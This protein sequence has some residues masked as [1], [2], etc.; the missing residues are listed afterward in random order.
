MA[1]RC[2]VSFTKASAA[3]PAP[4][5]SRSIKSSA[6]DPLNDALPFSDE[7]KITERYKRVDF[8]TLTLDALIE[9]PKIWTQ[10]YKVNTI[11]YKRG[12]DRVR[13]ANFCNP[14]NE[15]LFEERIRR[16]AIEPPAGK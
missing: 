15:R 4:T 2:N 5:A 11:T 16:R 12:P 6:P 9:D 13:V 8:D 10:P 14:D 1:T 3:S 7:I